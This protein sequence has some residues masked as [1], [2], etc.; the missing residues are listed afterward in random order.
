M[1]ARTSSFPFFAP[2]PSW[3]GRGDD[4]R[5]FEIM[6]DDGRVITTKV[7]VGEVKRAQKVGETKDSNSHGNY[8]LNWKDWE[9]RNRLWLSRKQFT[10]QRLRYNSN[11]FFGC[12]APQLE[13]SMS[14]EHHTLE[15]L[16][17]MQVLARMLNEYG[18]LHSRMLNAYGSFS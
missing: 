1:E 7:E 16:M 4:G 18:V 11:F 17:C 8:F 5:L 14:T 6:T 2:R 15:C 3:W 10:R 9:K 13:C 12:L